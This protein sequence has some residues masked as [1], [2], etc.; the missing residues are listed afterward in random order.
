MPLICGIPLETSLA[1]YPK[2]IKS[3]VDSDQH[4]KSPRVTG[5]DGVVTRLHQLGEP[6]LLER[7]LDV[8]GTT[9][10]AF[11][12]K[13]NSEKEGD[14]YITRK[15]R[16]V[17]MG[18]VATDSSDEAKPTS[19]MRYTIGESA[20]ASFGW[21]GT[22]AVARKRG[23]A[24]ALALWRNFHLKGKKVGTRRA[25]VRIEWAGMTSSKQTK[26]DTWM[27]EFLERV[28]QENKEYKIEY[29]RLKAEI[30]I[31]AIL[32]SGFEDFKKS[33]LRC[34]AECGV[35]VATLRCSRC[36]FAKYCSQVCQVDNW[37]Y[38][39]QYCGKEDTWAF[40][41]EKFEDLLKGF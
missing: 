37:K 12:M 28:E 8:K 15:G 34:R 14:V 24:L 6:E 36:H 10:F 19:G 35:E 5:S 31:N 7:L 30:G 13:A 27:A 23:T 41:D 22:A 18:L 16:V 20:P 26:Y 40:G 32:A 38:H 33:S 25:I 1:V 29:E 4:P 17:E 11:R 21:G 3:G 9:V 2:T 39:K